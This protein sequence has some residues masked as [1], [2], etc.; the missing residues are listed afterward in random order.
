M[1]SNVQ[2]RIFASAIADFSERRDIPF[3][4]WFDVDLEEVSKPGELAQAEA[5]AENLSWLFG[6]S[7]EVLAW[8][9]MS[10]TLEE[11]AKRFFDEFE[12]DGGVYSL[13]QLVAL[14]CSS[15]APQVAINFALRA[16]QA[17]MRAK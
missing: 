16:C 5:I 1:I 7:E 4:A 13:V 14:A 15:N 10:G 2:R 8:F 11:E 17:V 6:R 3:E 12:N 9:P